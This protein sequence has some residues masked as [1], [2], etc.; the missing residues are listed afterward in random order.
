M[1]AAIE[2]ISQRLGGLESKNAISNLS[3]GKTRESFRILLTY[4]DRWYLKGLH[5][6]EGLNSLLQKVKCESVTPSNAKKLLP[7]AEYHEK[8]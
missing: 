4:Y 1:I 8:P 3:I 6:R 2:R 5:N 7:Q